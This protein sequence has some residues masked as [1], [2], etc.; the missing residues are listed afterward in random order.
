MAGKVWLQGHEAGLAVRGPRDHI[1]APT[2][3]AERENEVWPGYE[4]SKPASSDVLPLVRHY[5]LKVPKPS[6]VVPPTRDPVFKPWSLLGTFH[7][8]TTT[9]VFIFHRRCS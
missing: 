6:Q 7:I 3:E 1:S 2:K 8:P 9:K 5:L 4:A